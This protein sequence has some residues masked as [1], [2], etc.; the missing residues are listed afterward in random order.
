MLAHDVRSLFRAALVASCMSLLAGCQ[1]ESSSSATVASG[2]LCTRGT[3]DA[4][5]DVFCAKEPATI[6][7]LHELESIVGLGL[8]EPD[9][10]AVTEAGASLAQP[11]IAGYLAV[12]L[13]DHST[14]L[15]ASLVSPINPRAI[16]LGTPTALAFNRGVQS[17]EIAT[18][19]RKKFTFNFYLV[20]FEQACNRAAGG[21]TPG[22]L[23]T[24]SIES[25]WTHVDIHDAEDLKDTPNDCRQCHQRGLEDPIL[26]MRELEGPW[27]HFF[28]PDGNSTTFPETTGSQIL[29]DYL[30]AKGNEEY[31]GVPSILLRQTSG[32]LLEESVTAVQP[33]VFDGSAIMNERWPYVDGGYPATP[34]RSATW[35]AGYE[36]FKRGEQLALPYFDPRPTDGAKQAT[37]TAAYQ[38]YRKK[39]IG[40]AEL[41][42]LSDIF[43]DDPQTRAELGLQTEP[44]ATPAQALVQACGTCHNEVLDQSISRARF[45]IDIAHMSRAELD[46]AVARLSL[47]RSSPDAMPPAGRR[48]LDAAGLTAL[49]GYLEN[50]VR[51]NADDAFLARAAKLGMAL[52][53][54]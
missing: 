45:D 17:V 51:T 11:G 6:G 54:N 40:A 41:P 19:D 28:E 36:A 13:L 48:Q 31:A 22:D 30:S 32:F 37:L 34:Q 43:S 27:T 26:L 25:N 2:D 7:S 53:F 21:C 3:D 24:P 49:I 39:E 23:Y 52:S 8:E 44:S 42:D 4:V 18:L 50:D 47:P 15:S 38:H 1:P 29:D 20:S 5:R 9:G 16:L 35:Y 10:G 12:A 14:S 46:V 33:L